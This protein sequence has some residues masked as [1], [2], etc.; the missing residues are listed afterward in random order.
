M[1]NEKDNGMVKMKICFVGILSHTFIKR[2][3]EILKKQFD[4]GVI[5]PPNKK[6]EWFHLSCFAKKKSMQTDIV[7]EWLA[8]W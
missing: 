1:D 4:V 6:K 2:D 5:E 3:Y 8:D 7:F